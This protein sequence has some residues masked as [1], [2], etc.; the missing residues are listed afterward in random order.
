MEATINKNT[1]LATALANPSF[2]QVT[3]IDAFRLAR[4]HWLSGRRLSLC[5]LAKE[6][7]ITR[8]KLYH[9]VGNKEWL[10]DEIIWS[11]AQPTFEKAI[12]ETPG[13]GIDHIVEV[14][15]YF[16]DAALSFKPLQQFLSHDPPYALRILTTDA[17]G[18]RTR[19]I[20]A[21]AA[22]IK[23]QADAGYVKLTTSPEEIA[24]MLI[25]T[26]ES[27]LYHDLLTGREPAV[28]K[29][30]AISRLLLSAGDLPGVNN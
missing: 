4:K 16:M 11:V 18:A 24:E 14:H 8:G 19:I 13:Q 17:R 2:P 21:A 22:H 5:E 25:H 23:A 29:A 15:R 7:G 26:N 20:A 12:K 27:L 30:C 28:E 1:P 10:L 9:W 3:P 6:L